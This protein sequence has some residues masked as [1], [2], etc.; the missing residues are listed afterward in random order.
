MQRSYRASLLAAF[1]LCWPPPGLFADEVPPTPRAFEIVAMEPTPLRVPTY[2]S[3]VPG[4]G[5]SGAQV[6]GIATLLYN[7]GERIPAHLSCQGER[8]ADKDPAEDG[9]GVC[10]MIGAC[11]GR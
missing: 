9:R 5:L 3:T 4:V 11:R 8:A 2:V 6:S 1:L 7:L 10:R